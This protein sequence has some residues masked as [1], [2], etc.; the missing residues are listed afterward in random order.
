MFYRKM[1]LAWKGTYSLLDRQRER[2]Q[3]SIDDWCCV[4]TNGSGFRLHPRANVR[5]HART[6]QMP[7]YNHF[8]GRLY[9]APMVFWVWKCTWILHVTAPGTYEAV[10]L[11]HVLVMMIIRGREFY[12]L[13][14]YTNYASCSIVVLCKSRMSL[15]VYHTGSVWSSA[16][17]QMG[18]ERI[19]FFW[20]SMHTAMLN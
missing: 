1:G 6:Y 13:I 10:L 14:T 3:L 20:S 12:S 19:H 15:H 17:W 18:H 16:I 9:A 2:D 7:A 8:Y 4:W 11:F 5:T